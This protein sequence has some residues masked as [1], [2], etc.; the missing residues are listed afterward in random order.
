MGTGGTGG[1]DPET[2]GMG[3]SD[4]DMLSGENM[5]TT[6]HVA[7]GQTQQP[8]W[9]WRTA[10]SGAAAGYSDPGSIYR[11]QQAKDLQQSEQD[12]IL[13]RQQ[14]G[15]QFQI[16][17]DAA[18]DALIRGRQKELQGVITQEEIKR[19]EDADRRE[20][21]KLQKD[22]EEAG[23]A[24][25]T[26][27]TAARQ[28]TNPDEIAAPGVQ[29]PPPAPVVSASQRAAQ[30][31]LRPKLDAEEDAILKRKHL[32]SQIATEEDNRKLAERKGAMYESL[33][34]YNLN[35]R[36]QKVTGAKIPPGVT[37]AIL[38][39]QGYDPDEADAVGAQFDAMTAEE[40]AAAEVAAQKMRKSGSG[41][42]VPMFGNPSG[43]GGTAS[44]NRIKLNSK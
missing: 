24:P 9:N 26:V 31:R 43:G 18:E 37:S 41:F 30:I 1:I 11:A 5:P 14:L 36:G 3:M 44:P 33:A 8:K 23:I 15:Q 22:I 10:L 34:D 27:P 6:V 25:S 35:R 7:P 21:E 42:V 29:M 38:R 32:A 20:R 19:R 39:M 16:Q 2:V 17:R 40:Q 4:I 13:K 12:N 28:F